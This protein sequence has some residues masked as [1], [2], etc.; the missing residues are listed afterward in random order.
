MWSDLSFFTKEIVTVSIENNAMDRFLSRLQ[1]NHHKITRCPELWTLTLVKKGWVWLHCYVTVSSEPVTCS[2]HCGSLTCSCGVV[3]LMV[4]GRWCAQMNVLDYRTAGVSSLTSS[5]KGVWP[6]RVLLPQGNTGLSLEIRSQA[7]YPYTV[8]IKPT[9]AVKE[10]K[11]G[12]PK[13]V[14]SAC[15]F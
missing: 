4:C 1:G 6:F 5:M 14:R 11:K 3:K 13:Y 7:P 12:K 15:Q 2:L 10:L 8:N 9:F